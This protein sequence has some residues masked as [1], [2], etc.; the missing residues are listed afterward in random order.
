MILICILKFVKRKPVIQSAQKCLNILE[1]NDSD[2]MKNKI[3]S[4]PLKSPKHPK[5]GLSKLT[6]LNNLL[7]VY[8]L[9]TYIYG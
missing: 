4:G 2:T 6:N 9:M 1:A 5:W 3:T 8:S 7:K